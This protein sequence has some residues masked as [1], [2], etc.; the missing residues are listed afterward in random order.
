M[1]RVVQLVDI[2]NEILKLRLQGLNSDT[3]IRLWR[4]V[5][6]LFKPKFDTHQTWQLTREQTPRVHWFNAVWFRGATPKYSVITWLAVH[7]RLATGARVQRWSPQTDAHCVLCSGHL[8]TRE[9]LYFSCSYS[10]KIWRDLTASLMG[11]RYTE[12][13]SS[14]L[15]ILAENRRSSTDCFFSDM[16][17]NALFIPYGEREMEENMEKLTRP[18][19]LC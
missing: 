7:D 2:E 18:R 6:D 5:G 9:H 16:L 10:K 12:V 3:D 19:R 15:E 14:I 1:H 11:S 17:S 8:E 4:G 13:W